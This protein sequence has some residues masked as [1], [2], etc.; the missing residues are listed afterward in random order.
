MS[1]KSIL[2]KNN[3]I[4]D[5]QNT[6]LKY[7]SKSHNKILNGKKTVIIEEIVK[8]DPAIIICCIRRILYFNCDTIDILIKK[9]ANYGLFKHLKWFK[10]KGYRFDRDIFDYATL[11]GN[12]NIMKWLYYHKY[13]YGEKTFEN[14]AKNGNLENMKWL[15]NIECDHDTKTFSS[16]A[17]NGNLANL[18]WLFEN[19][20]RY[21]EWTVFNA[22]DNGNLENIKWILSNL[23]K[24]DIS[25]IKL[26]NKTQVIKY[27]IENDIIDRNDEWCFIYAI[28]NGNLDTI[29]L[30]HEN[31][32]EPP[33]YV[34][35]DAFMNGNLENIKWLFD[36]KIYNVFFDEY[37]FKVAV[38]NDNL[39][40][41]KWLYENC[42]PN[43]VPL[44]E[45]IIQENIDIIEWM[46]EN[47]FPIEKK[48]IDEIIIENIEV[49]KC[50]RKHN[51][52]FP[53]KYHID[54]LLGDNLE[55]IYEK[56]FK[57]RN[58][59]NITILLKNNMFCDIKT[60]W[61]LAEK[62]KINFNNIFYCDYY[63]KIKI[64]ELSLEK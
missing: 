38:E 41:I 48:Y 34:F 40:N 56:N 20:F 51:L 16:A 15:L 49:I 61:N 14:A 32:F 4:V 31:D 44:F 28:R 59:K 8:Y 11:S 63:E 35:T 18:K 52:Y 42:R 64:L 7:L 21:D 23:F 47:N 25:N 22:F 37:L 58:I 33:D 39:E 9:C 54:N 50:L 13:S 60:F 45:A 5:L 36:K 26:T 17:K 27:L 3:I 55:E 30:L 24:K 29:K 46:L 12:I 19:D 6:I 62:Y 57:E 43:Y 10:K 2:L 1:I 53:S